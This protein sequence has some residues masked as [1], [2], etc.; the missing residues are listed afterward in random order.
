[1]KASEFI[2]E[3][4]SEI[5]DLEKKLKS[6]YPELDTLFLSFGD[7]TIRITSIIINKKSRKE[8]IGTS[9]MQDIVDYADKHGYRITLSPGSRDDRHGTTSTNRLVKFYKRFGF[10]QNKGRNKDFTISDSM[11]REPK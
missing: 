6:K 9:V 5:D 11:Y 4:Y 8:G 10:V 7:N 1:M 2:I 3:S